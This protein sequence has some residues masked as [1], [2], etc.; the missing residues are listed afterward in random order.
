MKYLWMQ[1]ENSQKEKNDK[2]LNRKWNWTWNNVHFYLALYLCIAW[3]SDCLLLTLF[4]APFSYFTISYSLFLSVTNTNIF[5]YWSATF[6]SAL[7]THFY[8]VLLLPSFFLSLAYLVCHYLSVSVFFVC[9][10]SPLHPSVYMLVT[11]TSLVVCLPLST[12]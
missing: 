1:Q 5:S 3:L 2:Y 6:F 10:S 11:F 9:L 12:L 4:L 7:L 8:N